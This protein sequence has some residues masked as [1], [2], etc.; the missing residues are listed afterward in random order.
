MR[1]H[2][3]RGVCL[4]LIVPRARHHIRGPLSV[5]LLIMVNDPIVQSSSVELMLVAALG[6][7]DKVL[8]HF[9]STLQQ[10]KD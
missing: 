6:C 5:I 8:Y 2:A 1:R 7:S 3:A 9:R 10:E 4:L